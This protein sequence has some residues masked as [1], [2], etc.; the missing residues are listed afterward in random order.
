MSTRARMALRLGIAFLLVTGLFLPRSRALDHTFA[1]AQQHVE[2][3]HARSTSALDHAVAQLPPISLERKAALLACIDYHLACAHQ[4]LVA[5]IEARQAAPDT[6]LA[7]LEAAEEAEYRTTATR[8][9]SLRERI[10][11]A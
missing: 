10:A 2:L 11:S 7:T 4:D 9:R 6:R 5:A 3:V 1:V 8:L